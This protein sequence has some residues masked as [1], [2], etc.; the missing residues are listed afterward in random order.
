[1][2]KDASKFFIDRSRSKIEA[3]ILNLGGFGK[4]FDVVRRAL[5]TALYQLDIQIE[6]RKQE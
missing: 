3:A 1:M 2:N 6:R 5:Y 4:E